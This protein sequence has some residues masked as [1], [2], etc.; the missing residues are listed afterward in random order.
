MTAPRSALDVDTAPEPVGVKK[1]GTTVAVSDVCSALEDGVKKL[2]TK[3]DAVLGRLALPENDKPDAEAE[4][5]AFCTAVAGKLPEAETETEAD[6]ACKAL[7]LLVRCPVLPG[8][9]SEE[10]FGRLDVWILVDEGMAVDGVKKLGTRVVDDAVASALE[11]GVKKLGTSDV[12][13]V[14]TLTGALADSDPDAEN[15]K[16]AFDDAAERKDPDV[17]GVALAL[18]GALLVLGALAID[19][20]RVVV[21]VWRAADSLTDTAA[22]G[23]ASIATPED[24]ED[25]AER[26]TDPLGVKKAEEKRAPALS[27]AD[28]DADAVAAEGASLPLPTAVALAGLKVLESPPSVDRD[29]ESANVD[30]LRSALA[31]SLLLALLVIEVKVAV[32][33]RPDV[34][35]LLEITDADA[36]LLWLGLAD[37]EKLKVDDD[38]DDPDDVLETDDVAVSL[39]GT[40]VLIVGAV[41]EIVGA[42]LVF[43]ADALK[44]LLTDEGGRAVA[45]S[46][47]VPNDAEAVETIEV[48]VAPVEA[49][50][51]LAVVNIDCGELV[52]A[53]VIVL[54][55][56]ARKL[57]LALDGARDSPEVVVVF[58]FAVAEEGETEAVTA[59]VV[60]VLSTLARKLALARAAED[61]DDLRG[62]RNEDSDVGVGVGVGVV[63]KL[64]VAL[65]LELELAFARA[66]LAR[67][68]SLDWSIADTDAREVADRPPAALGLNTSA[69][70]FVSDAVAVVA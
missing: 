26:A 55:L 4:T 67:P 32:L 65:E 29:A 39:G 16:A 23:V 38:D 58:A 46:T 50:D 1:L 54:C 11:E 21:R 45:L 61:A 37:A 3:V 49:N 34:S 25:A 70:V 51:S 57:V 43:D 12:T 41:A 15:E 24:A 35:G 20:L 8:E 53:L 33:K 7:A 10:C 52:L 13:D 44:L 14:L 64:V 42:L 6:V 36:K 27:I 66:V 69:A 47:P 28:A 60:D 9:E 59:P 18:N 31:L 48:L 2:D 68:D 30:A 63:V 19:A 56:P 17:E 62:A 22:D 40:V 5:V